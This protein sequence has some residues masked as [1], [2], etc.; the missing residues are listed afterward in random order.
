MHRSEN[1]TEIAGRKM[2]YLVHEN[3]NTALNGEFE[4]PF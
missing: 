1:K 2:C 4:Q 3:Q